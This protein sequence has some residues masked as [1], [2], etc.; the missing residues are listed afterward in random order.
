VFDEA[1]IR[2]LGRWRFEAGASERQFSAEIEFK[3]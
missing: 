2:T 1:V 3:R